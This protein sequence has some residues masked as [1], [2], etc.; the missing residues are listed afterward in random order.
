[1]HTAGGSVRI[2]C[3][4]HFVPRSDSHETQRHLHARRGRTQADRLL[5][6]AQRGNP[7]LEFLRARARSDP[8]AA[9]SRS[10]F[11]YFLFCDI[12]WGKWDFHFSGPPVSSPSATVRSKKSLGRAEL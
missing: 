3:R 2:G 11:F 1:D 6:S 7:A 12:W 9:Q 5:C 8:A 4:D 10:D